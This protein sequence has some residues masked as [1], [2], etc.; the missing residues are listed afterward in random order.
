MENRHGFV[1]QGDPTRN[2][3]HAERRAALDMVHRHSPGSTRHLTA[4]PDKGNDAAGVVID[5]RRACVTPNVGRLPR[6]P[7]A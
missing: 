5:L 3:G 4:G 1:V 7:G 6:L 2:D